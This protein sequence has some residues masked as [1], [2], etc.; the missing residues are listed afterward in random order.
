MSVRQEENGT[1]TAQVWYHD[2]NGERRHKTKRG[3]ETEEEVLAWHDNYAVE[4]EGSVSSSLAAFV[5]TYLEDIK[6]R[7]RESTYENK[8]YTINSKILPYLGHMRMDEIEPV[9]IVRWQNRLM[10]ATNGRGEHYSSTYLRTVNNQLT[11]IF[12]H[13]SRLYGLQNNPCKKT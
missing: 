10:K 2:Y 6:P 7:I 5:D 1:W 12:N 4:A 8:V 3:F 13:A 9:D 11:A